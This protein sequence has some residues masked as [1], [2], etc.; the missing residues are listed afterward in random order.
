MNKRFV[1]QVGNNKNV[2]LYKVIHI[3]FVNILGSSYMFRP[4]MVT[5]REVVNTER[6]N[7]ILYIFHA[8]MKQEWYWTS[9][10]K[11]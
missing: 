4:T 2:I 10:S 8:I 9:V 6:V 5:F 1:Y 11:I 7:L 3:P